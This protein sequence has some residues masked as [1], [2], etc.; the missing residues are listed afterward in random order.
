VLFR[1]WQGLG[2]TYHGPAYDVATFCPASPAKPIG[3][4]CWQLDN[5]PIFK[6]NTL[7]AYCARADLIAFGHP[8]SA[9]CGECTEIAVLRLDGNYNRITVMTVDNPGGGPG[10]SPEL[11]TDGKEYLTQGTGKQLGD[12]LPF[13]WRKVNCTSAT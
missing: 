7:A 9:Q 2:I 3:N 1:S 5:N 11:S 6:T 10:S 4:A 12:R 8:A 13:E